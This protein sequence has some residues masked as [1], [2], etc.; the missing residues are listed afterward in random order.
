MVAEPL[1]EVCAIPIL[2]P[3]KGSQLYVVV[4]VT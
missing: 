4:A 2:L 3:R 1:I